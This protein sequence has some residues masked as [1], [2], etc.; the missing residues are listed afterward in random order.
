MFQNSVFYVE[1]RRSRKINDVK[2]FLSLYRSILDSSLYNLPV[3]FVNL[4]KLKIK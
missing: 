2:E 3:F 4:V 1:T